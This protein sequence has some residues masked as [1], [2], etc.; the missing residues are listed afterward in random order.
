MVHDPAVAKDRPDS[1][2]QKKIFYIAQP[3]PDIFQHANPS[4]ARRRTDLLAQYELFINNLGVM[5][6]QH[7]L[8][9][10]KVPMR[11]FALLRWHKDSDFPVFISD[12][13]RHLTGLNIKYLKHVLSGSLNGGNSS[14]ANVSESTGSGTQRAALSSFD[15]R[16]RDF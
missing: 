7:T 2:E 16:N 5:S 10:K 3:I 1:A 14:F 6:P 4:F 9:C 8:Q 11:H 15:V 12:L 13:F